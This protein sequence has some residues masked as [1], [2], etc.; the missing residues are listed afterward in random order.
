LRDRASALGIAPASKLIV[1]GYGSSNGVNV[2]RFS[3]G[4]S[5]V[6][7]QLGLPLDAPVVGYVGRLTRDKGIPDLVE[8]FDDLLDAEPSAHLLLVGWV[9]A[10][11]DRLPF[12]YSKKD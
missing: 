4:R 7:L 10:A 2:N 9:D 3:P 5:D 11:E 12:L 8:S 6:R 1:Q